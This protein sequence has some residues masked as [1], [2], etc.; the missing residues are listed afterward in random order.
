[1]KTL[2]LTCCKNVGTVGKGVGG[3]ACVSKVSLPMPLDW[4]QNRWNCRRRRRRG[5]KRVVNKLVLVLT[6]YSRIT[7]GQQYP[8]LCLYHHFFYH[9]G[10]RSYKSMGVWV[11][12]Q[13]KQKS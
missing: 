9:I 3:G 6:S 11:G 10:M 7:H 12:W 5:G 8:M 4:S 13:M 1:M 2:V